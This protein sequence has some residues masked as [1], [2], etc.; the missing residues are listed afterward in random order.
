MLSGM[1]IPT[2]VYTALEQTTSYT[3]DS[4]PDTFVFAPR[5][6]I[7]LGMSVDYGPVTLSGFNMPIT[8]RVSTGNL[9]INGVSYGTGIVSVSPG[10]SLQVS[11]IAGTSYGT[12]YSG[13]LSLGS[14]APIVYRLETSMTPVLVVVP[15]PVVGPITG[16]GGGGGAGSSSSSSTNVSS[17]QGVSSSPMMQ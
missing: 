9:Q 15:T 2:P 12:T 4:V 7:A 1:M 11:L 16:G 8:A 10:D 3:F 6:G 14:L 13:Q 5:L 17:S